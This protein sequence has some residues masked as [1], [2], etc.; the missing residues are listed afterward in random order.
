MFAF[1]ARREPLNSRMIFL[2]RL[3][4]WC[5][6]LF[7]GAQLFAATTREERALTEAQL[8]FN[9]RSFDR[10]ETA[11]TQFLKNYPKSSSL[12]A[13]ALLLAQAQFQQGKIPASLATLALHRANAGA[14]AD[15]F[16]YWTAEAQ[17]ASGD[18]AGAAENFSAV[19]KN[20]PQSTLRLAAAVEAAAA[21]EKT[22]AWDNLTALLGEN[23]GV[24]Q[25]AAQTNAG[26]AQIIAG[27][28]L[29][30]RALAAQEKF[31]ASSDV[32]AL[33]DTQPLDAELKW[34]KNSL[35]FVNRLAVNDAPAALALTTNLLELA[36]QQ[37]NSAWQ[38]DAS[39]KR[40]A[41][42]EKMGRLPEAAAT[43]RENLSTNLPVENQREAVLGIA[44]LAAA[45]RDFAGAESD[46][47]A[48]FKLHPAPDVAA[49]VRL[50][51][52]ELHLK[53]FAEP[54][55]LA[56]ARAEF[57]RLLNAA[58][59][60]PLAAR[61]YL[62][63]GWANWLTDKSELALADFKNAAARLPATNDLA[64]AIFKAADAEFAL[65]K[66]AAA[67]D[68]YRL[69]LQKF[70]GV[71][72]VLNALGDRALYQIVL[73]SL[74]LRDRAGTEAALKELLD[75]WPKTGGAESGLL[76]AAESFSDFAA[77]PAARDLLHRFAEKYPDSPLR[78]QAEFALAR[79]FEHERNWPAAVTNHAAWLEKFST[80]AL[81]PQVAY[82]EAWANF[83]AGR[84]AEAFDRFTNFTARFPAD[85]CAPLA[86]WWVADYF[87]R[88]RAFEPAEKN[89]KEIFQ[90]PAW[91]K[92]GLYFQAQWMAGRAAFARQGWRDAVA[93][94]EPLLNDTNCP[95]ALGTQ[96][97]FTYGALMKVMPS[98][99]TNNPLANLIIA[100]NIYDQIFRAN[101]TNETGLRARGEL[102]DCAALL[103][104]FATAT[105]VYLLVANSSFASN[106]AALYGR[107]KVGLGQVLEK[108][109]ES[110][111]AEQR[112][113]L[114]QQ[115]K[116]VY[117]DV[118]DRASNPPHD[119]LQ[120]E[121][122]V[123]SAG[124]HALP[125]LTADGGDHSKFF[126][127]M[128]KLLPQM[129]DALEKKK[130]ALGAVKN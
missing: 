45:Q 102:A 105:N 31:V 97:R 79:T 86:Q 101:P 21:W 62:G 53:D 73:A 82:A 39:A 52:G 16:A 7:C 10:A 66:F 121:S 36:R 22:G 122:W 77:P 54:N 25:R 9:Q 8:N 67:R 98:A 35:L 14:L 57:D 59:D 32:L 40:A 18:F 47:E 88:A 120:D 15:K 91:N 109:A 87:F 50:T 37:T 92:S 26:G 106:N 96:A 19:A 115:A 30:A 94:L 130:A 110:L 89:Y 80:N 58:P 116:N 27:H 127:R 11:L 51:L 20:F 71:A 2:R 33:L 119:E 69:V 124:L 78:P 123:K 43:R 128:E 125:L 6:L 56:A 17:F 41:V 61:A 103:G 74:E 70:S 84:E 38:A 72:A 126:E 1:R 76:L 104:D 46:L 81:A 34:K 129:K 55:H 114:L 107:A 100:T 112:A 48:F 60:G 23:G 108:M 113:L 29:L 4:V 44:A 111:P 93:D 12:S 90:N 5:A 85:S 95:A 13:A 28:L 24:F 3:P 63:R 75:R 117:F 65:K 42:L 64:V 118:V 68:D 83:Q 49:L 99:D